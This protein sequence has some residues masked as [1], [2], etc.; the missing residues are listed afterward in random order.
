[1][2]INK[3]YNV[4]ITNIVNKLSRRME[5]ILP[6]RLNSEAYISEQ[7]DNIFNKFREN[8][9]NIKYNKNNVKESFNKLLSEIDEM[10]DDN[11]DDFIM[12][13]KPY[14]KTCLIIME[15]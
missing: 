1:M 4:I 14:K 15:Y 8:I 13:R 5:N 7:L 12:A 11:Q 9:S 6:I 10:I 2:E 3:Q